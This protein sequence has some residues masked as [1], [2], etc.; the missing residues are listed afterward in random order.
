V[1]GYFFGG[2]EH[3]WV[4]NVIV[5][6]IPDPFKDRFGVGGLAGEPP[7]VPGRVTGDFA[8]AAGVSYGE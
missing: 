3:F 6:I 2:G 5:D 1:F 8:Y 4:P 7:V